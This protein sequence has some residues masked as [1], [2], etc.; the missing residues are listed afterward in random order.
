[1]SLGV[2][3]VYLGIYQ[4]QTDVLKTMKINAW[5][6]RIQ[7]VSQKKKELQKSFDICL[8]CKVTKL[9]ILIFDIFFNLCS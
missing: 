1:M 6:L 5:Y 4:G 2:T 3:A 9:K 8:S 7:Y